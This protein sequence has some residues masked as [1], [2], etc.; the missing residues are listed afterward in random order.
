MMQRPEPLQLANV[1]CVSTISSGVEE[2]RAP[3][4]TARHHHRPVNQATTKHVAT[5]I[6]PISA[7]IDCM[8]RT[9]DGT[10]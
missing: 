10:G 7:R 5:Q 9:E 2:I 6:R 1:G 4:T 8:S 3:D